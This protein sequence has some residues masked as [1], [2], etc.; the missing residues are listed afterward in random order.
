MVTPDLSVEEIHLTAS[1]LP[2]EPPVSD[3]P[4]V[5]LRFDLVQKNPSRGIFR[6][7]AVGSDE[8]LH[9]SEQ[10]RRQQRSYQVGLAY[11]N[12]EPVRHLIIAKA[13][14]YFAAACL[15]GAIVL[16]V[17]GNTSLGARLPVPL[18]PG[19]ILCIAFAIVCLLGMF[20]RSRLLLHYR[21]RYGQLNLV[22][23]LWGRPSRHQY[24]D[25]VARLSGAIREA[26]RNHEGGLERLL[27][28]EL[29]EHR[30]LQENGIVDAPSYEAAKQR[31][32]AAHSGIGERNPATC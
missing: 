3:A 25:F 20:Y 6:Q 29:R 21:T 11:L 8:R 5:R 32:L 14:G 15:L 4:P 9:V 28:D 24:H 12:P 13:W 7:F 17:I 18:F 19:V 31:I 23:L 2:D 26:Q 16:G 30:R 27:A 10:I 22:E 1:A